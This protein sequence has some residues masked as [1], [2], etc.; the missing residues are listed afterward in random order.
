MSRDPTNV[1]RTPEHI[2]IAQVEGPLH[3]QHR[4]QQITACCVLNAF[5]FTC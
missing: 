2:A 3:R 4:P 5:W 1:S